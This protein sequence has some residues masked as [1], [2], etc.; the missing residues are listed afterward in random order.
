[1]APDFDD[2]PTIPASADGNLIGRRIG[3]YRIVRPLGHGGMGEVYLATRDDQEYQKN[4]ALKIVRGGLE[5]GLI[6]RRFRHERQILAG[7]EHPHIAGLLDGGTTPEGLPY[8]VMEYVDGMPIDTYCDTRR[9]TVRERLALFRTVSSAVQYAHEHHVIHRDIKPTNILVSADGVPKLLDFG[10]A[11]LLTSAGT[12]GATVTSAG[13]LTPEFAS[14]EQIRGESV[15]EAADIYA[16]GVLLYRLLT[17]RSPYR[18][19][20]E[21]MHELARA[22]CEDPPLPPST[23][24]GTVGRRSVVS[25]PEAT[26]ERIG[27]ARGDS[28]STL[29]RQLSG[30]LDSIVLKALR[31]E[32]QQ[33]Y[34]SVTEFSEDVGR[35]LDGRPVAARRGTF[36]YRLR[37]FTQR[38][39][40]AL[41][42][43]STIV[44]L[45]GAL[46][47][48]VVRGT[49]AGRPAGVRTLAVLP[50]QGLGSTGGDEYLGLAVTDA[51][52][53]QLSNLPQIA[54]RPTTAIQEYETRNADA[55]SIAKRLQVEAVLEGRFQRDGDRIRLTA[56]LINVR[57]ATPLWADTFDE[58]FTNMFA[59]QDRISR[60]VAVTL[61]NRLTAED[62]GRLVTRPTDDHRA[63][64]L[65]LR[66]RYQWNKRTEDGL[67][68]AIQC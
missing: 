59:V 1:M 54:V 55:V 5:S 4:V 30:D 37:K 51:L 29:R 56:Q 11:K 42:A 46:A 18:V 10:I 32:P 27:T 44:V 28:I 61:L 58:Q 25:R 35:Y 12:E 49:P 43:I 67:K 3:A 17:G 16:L 19:S 64:D 63:Y 40:A 41:L 8:I 53:T 20:Q 45:I 2:A 66:G 47:A 14:P 52:I 15:D 26:S 22:I 23:A 6:L 50:F 36:R 9:L 38:H 57:T 65:Y 24:I 62:S 31:K 7:L 68:T 13:M 48:L 21:R 33:R 60:R 39:R 34:A